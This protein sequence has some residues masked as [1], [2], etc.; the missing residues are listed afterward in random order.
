[1]GLKQNVIGKNT[2][3]KVA[4]LF[5]KHNYW[6]F[7]IPKG[8][9][10]QPFDIIARHKNVTFFIDVKH[11]DSDFFPFERIEPNQLSSMKY[12]N[13]VAEIQDNMGFIINKNESFYFVSYFECVKMME[14]GKKGVNIK[15]LINL[16]LFLEGVKN[17]DNRF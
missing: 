2:E 11:L 6:A 12:A 15:D 7:I 1:M 5:K 17:G 16:E 14:Q 4:N 9:N 10:G 13:V 8:L 3:L